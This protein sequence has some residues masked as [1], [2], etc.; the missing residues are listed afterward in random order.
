MRKMVNKMYNI[1]KW[2]PK[3][4]SVSH[5]NL[6][7][8]QEEIWDNCCA[9]FSFP[10]D[11]DSFSDYSFEF[12]FPPSVEEGFCF[13]HFKNIYESYMIFISRFWSGQ[14]NVSCLARVGW[15]YEGDFPVLCS[16][17]Q[18]WVPLALSNKLESCF[19]SPPI[20]SA[21]KVLAHPRVFRSCL[22]LM[23]KLLRIIVFQAGGLQT[24][25]WLSLSLCY[26][27]AQGL[28]PSVFS[29][30]IVLAHSFS[31]SVFLS[32]L[33]AKDLSNRGRWGCFSLCVSPVSRLIM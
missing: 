2:V 5:W 9:S 19:F 30:C 13:P 31:F 23:G 11:Q 28:S 8:V 4:S 32:A 33:R 18:D 17:W 24:T 1:Y 12:F 6:C 14:W 20:A 21:E 10:L 16:S 29:P 22:L 15:G 7:V 27:V 25:A 26:T 3:R